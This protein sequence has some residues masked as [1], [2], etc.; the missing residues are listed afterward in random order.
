[1]KTTL[2]L[3][4]I[5]LL[6]PV[7][8][9]ARPN[10]LT[11]R[12]NYPQFR[13]LSGLP[14]GGYGV[15]PSGALDFSGA[16]SLSTPIG[17]TPGSRSFA[18][19]Y[20]STSYSSRFRLF[21]SGDR[22]AG[23]NGTAF[24]TGGLTLPFGNV[25]AGGMLLSG[26]GD[27]VLNL[28]FSPKLEV[29]K[30]G[31]AVGVQDVT[32]SGGANG[33]VIDLRDGGGTSRSLYAVA[34]YDLGQGSFVSLGKGDRRFG[35]AFGN[36]ALQVHPRVKLLAEYDV[37]NWNVGVALNPGRLQLGAPGDRTL[38]PT[39]YVGT[40]RGKYPTLALTLSF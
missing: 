30:L 20:G 29:R 6:L 21:D 39:L 8:G 24:L 16:M 18:V 15:L 22:E 17:Y 31:V 2:A 9:L 10:E 7:V 5:A 27:T 13:T 37:F 28:Q 11:G 38:Q 12:S 25:S 40:V 33:E 3:V 26:K 4:P 34:T 23:A 36:V 35:G 1:M 19:G 14:G 32:N